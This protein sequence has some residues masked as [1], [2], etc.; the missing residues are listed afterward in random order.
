MAGLR[1]T[2]EQDDAA[3]KR[4]QRQQVGMGEYEERPADEQDEHA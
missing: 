1:I 3:R 4:H 2:D